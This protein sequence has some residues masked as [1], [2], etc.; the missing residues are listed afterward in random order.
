M[1]CVHKTRRLQ[2]QTFDIL[3]RAPRFDQA[4]RKT[5]HA[6][7]SV[8]HNGSLV[9]HDVEHQG[10][11]G[12]GGNRPEVGRGELHSNQLATGFRVWLEAI[13]S[14]FQTSRMN[15]PGTL[16]RT[17]PFFIFLCLCLVY[18]GTVSAASE[19]P[20]QVWASALT[21][22]RLDQPP[23]LE[24]VIVSQT[25]QDDGGNT[26]FRFYPREFRLGPDGL[27]PDPVAA[28]E[29]PNAHRYR[30]Q[31]RDLGQIFTIPSNLTAPLYLRAV[32]LRVGPMPNANEGGA[33]GASVSMQLFE[34]HGEPVI[35]DSGTSG[36]DS[37]RWRTFDSS[38]ATTDDY[39]IGQSFVSLGV[40]RG[41]TL[42]D[43]I[44]P[45]DY[46]QWRLHGDATIRLEPGG[47]Y[48]FMV[49]FDEPAEGRGLALANRNTAGWA[50]PVPFGP[51][52]GGYAIRRM[53][54]SSRFEDVFFNPE[55]RDD[56]AVGFAAATLPAEL[57]MRA[58][59]VPGTVGY[60]DVDTYRDFVFWIHAG[61]ERIQPWP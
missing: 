45:H 46:L 39:V 19:E 38:R 8:P 58:A 10:G 34:V 44:A 2:W 35:H 21:V 49:L 41:G 42:P 40:A 9:H 16:V 60:P 37:S 59:I 23:G 53:G 57:A 28:R 47:T 13:P 36:T 20:A 56:A 5:D 51:Y 3:F 25:L 15:S 50:E 18:P 24:E 54:E 7:I 43:G 52:P 27:L 55:D 22:Q 14:P 30:L 32:T 31:D 12:A 4:G 26:R 17:A 33:D 11:T 29:Y 6:R 1:Q 48:A 61:P